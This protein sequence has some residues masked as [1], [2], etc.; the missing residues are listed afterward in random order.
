EAPAGDVLVAHRRVGDLV[1]EVHARALRVVAE[2]DR[3]ARTAG[4]DE[5]PRTVVAVAEDDGLVG[6][7]LQ[8]LARGGCAAGVADLHG[9]ARTAVDAG[10]RPPPACEA[11]AVRE[12]ADEELARRADDELALQGELQLAEDGGHRD[13]L[14]WDLV[15]VRVPG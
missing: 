4:R 5:L 1:A 13:V 14:G 6:A 7:Q 9:S 12:A 3:H 10:A 2:R 11:L 8:D 15:R